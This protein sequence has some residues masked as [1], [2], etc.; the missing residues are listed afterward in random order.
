M[1]GLIFA[2]DSQRS[3]D[4][5]RAAGAAALARMRHRGPDDE[6]LETDEAWLLGHRRLSIVDL[7]GSHQPMW[8]DGRR[9]CL[10]FNGEIYNYS[11]LRSTLEPHWRFRTRGDTEVLLAGLVLRGPDFLQQT[12]GMWALALW[13]R[14]EQRLLMARDRMGK[15]PLFFRAA[16]ITALSCSSEL[17]A[18]RS[19]S[20]KPWSEDTDATADFLRYGFA[21]PGN[22]AYLGVREVLP[23]HVV[24]WRP[25]EPLQQ[26]PYWRLG[27][28]I[29]RGCKQDAVEEL[30]HRL[31][32]AVSRRLV[33][34]VEVGAFLSGGVDSSLI[35]SLAVEL[36]SAPV[37]TFAIGF[38]DPSFDERPFARR[39]ASR[40]GTQHHEE[41]LE[42]LE[43]DALEG[44]VFD[45]VGEPFADPSLLP[46]AM[47]ARLAARHLKVVLSGDGGDELFSGYQRYQARAMLRWYTR[48]PRASR[49][50]I[51]SGV[52]VLPEPL[53]HHSRS[54]I[55][56]AHLFVEA[57]RREGNDEGYV[58]PRLLSR[59]QLALVAPE[60]T[61]RGHQPPMLGAAPD[62]D[63]VQEM[64]ALDSLIYLPQDILRKVDRATMAHSL[65]AR[66]P[67]LDSGLV[68][69][70]LS[71]P[72]RWHRRGLIGKRLLREAF[73]E[74]L[75]PGIW[76]R[77]KQG[78]SVPVGAWF[79]G[80][81]GDELRGLAAR[82][83][84]PLRLQGVER[85]LHIH[86]GNRR[87][88]GLVL[89][90]LYV[91]LLWRARQVQPC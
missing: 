76:Q 80:A 75:E 20:C 71:L 34:D 57:A 84:G 25:G 86:R 4:E 23:G 3:A 33:A 59:Q 67:F 85:L 28:E 10:V 42:V 91:Y 58:A 37:Q 56:K 63:S 6:G 90:A 49:V 40:L 62:L 26:R 7:S 68:A 30:R 13:D 8:D 69:F 18:L 29:F 43:P 16:S 74:R 48:L 78:F 79:R 53:V 12:E 46:T 88:L 41:C 22:T 87:D 47:V 83:P 77:R 5:L 1:C 27:L 21:L 55:K 54:L 17:P 45:V 36:S 72:R 81:L 38:A 32:T 15:K 51:E 24:H 61:G 11:E 31:R 9:Y 39:V 60:L 50:L 14:C 70:S 52:R 73:G 82:N 19:L 89:W 35:S 44:L 66:A 64:M 65:E 2:F